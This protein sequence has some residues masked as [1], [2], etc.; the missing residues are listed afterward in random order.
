MASDPRGA[1]PS[2]SKWPKI[3]AIVLGVW[4]VVEWGPTLGLLLVL[5]TLEPSDQPFDAALWRTSTVEGSF[6]E[7]TRDSMLDD[8]LERGLL[9][10][11]TPPEVRELLGPE[12]RQH[13]VD[14]ERPEALYYLLSTGLI[15]PWVLE[16]EFGEDGRV[17]GCTRFNG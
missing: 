6:Y 14:L 5:Y 1:A 4:F 12:Y 7:T 10:G 16:V 13:G 3:I 9:D 11:L 15:D 8:L 17:A 2:W